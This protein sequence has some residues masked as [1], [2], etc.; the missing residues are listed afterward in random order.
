[1]FSFFKAIFA[2]LEEYVST[3][4]HKFVQN[5]IQRQCIV[6]KLKNP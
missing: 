1:M 2:D 6:K 5:D 4:K 3:F